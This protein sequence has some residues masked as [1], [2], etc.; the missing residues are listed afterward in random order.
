MQIET[1]MSDELYQWGMW[2]QDCPS[3]SLNYP[4]SEPYTVIKGGVGL[5][6]GDERALE[7]DQ[8]IAFL[9]GRDRQAV[10]AIKLR[11]VCGF[12]YR[13]IGTNLGVSKDRAQRLIDDSVSW[14]K[15]YFVGKRAA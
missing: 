1:N 12:A 10:K 11:F 14:L 6:I 8:A 9:F 2:V 5:K 13:D 15:G 7:I 3:R 4:S